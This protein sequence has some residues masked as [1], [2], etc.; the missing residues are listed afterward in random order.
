MSVVPVAALPL[1]MGTLAMRRSEKWADQ[2][3]GVLA[4]TIAEVDFELAEPV[5]AVLRAAIDRHDLG[6]TPSRTPDLAAAFAG[7][8]ARRMGWSVDPEQVVPVTD[9][10][11]G[12]ASLCR[13]LTELGDGWAIPPTTSA[14]SECSPPKPPS[15]TAIR[16]WI[17][18]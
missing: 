11:I 8:A 1:E 12:V 13:T 4:S 15:L 17:R 10:M 14:C 3:A 7:F 6:Y 9:V 18:S 5:V 16:G 2:P